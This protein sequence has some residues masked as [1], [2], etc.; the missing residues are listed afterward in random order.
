M[1]FCLYEIIVQCSMSFISCPS[2][3]IS[4]G[5]HQKISLIIN[6]LQME[7][8]SIDS[9]IFKRKLASVEVRSFLFCS[10]HDLILNMPTTAVQRNLEKNDYVKFIE[11]KATEV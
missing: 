4:V 3:T 7:I 1:G 8:V 6:S 10:I 5:L 9:K 2:K 11:H